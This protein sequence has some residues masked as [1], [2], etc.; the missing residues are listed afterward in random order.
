MPLRFRKSIKA[1]PFRV[2]LSHRGIGGSVGAGGLRYSTP[3]K[4]RRKASGNPCCLNLLLLFPILLPARVLQRGW[5][6][7][8]RLW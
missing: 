1:G 6:G 5:H 3:R 2:N 7:V 8:S 4:T